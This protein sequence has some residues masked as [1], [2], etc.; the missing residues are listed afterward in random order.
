M[1][2][3]IKM[4]RNKVTFPHSRLHFHTDNK[5]FCSFFG[6]GGV[7]LWLMRRKI[8]TL[9]KPLPEQII[10]RAAL[11]AFTSSRALHSLRSGGDHSCTHSYLEEKWTV[12]Q[13]RKV[14]DV[15]KCAP[16]HL[17]HICYLLQ[18]EV[19]KKRRKKIKKEG[20]ILL[21]V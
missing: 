6:S 15:P 5:S 17:L 11:L 3:T 8:S 9:C 10:R 12:V 16:I 19:L 4:V 1:C 21:F 18:K 14:V 2:E 13:K 20:F 7:K